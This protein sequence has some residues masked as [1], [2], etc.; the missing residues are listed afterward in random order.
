MELVLKYIINEILYWIIGL[1]IFNVIFGIVFN[2]IILI[3]LIICYL[4]NGKL[5][6]N[7]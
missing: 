5:V 1:E 3:F 4:E 2:V 6:F 7:F